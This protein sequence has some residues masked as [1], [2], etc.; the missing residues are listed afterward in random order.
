M[1]F[2]IVESHHFGLPGDPVRPSGGPVIRAY[3]ED[4]GEGKQELCLALSN[5]CLRLSSVFTD[6]QTTIIEGGKDLGSYDFTT[7]GC[8]T[9]GNK[10][11]QVNCQTAVWKT[12]GMYGL[13]VYAD[14]NESVPIR[15]WLRFVIG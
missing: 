5:D 10:V 12:A 1:N 15:Y 6:M 8:Y 2:C 4:T 3:I 9:E 14:A 7:S 13:A 11:L